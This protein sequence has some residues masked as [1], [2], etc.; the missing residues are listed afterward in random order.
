MKN[1]KEIIEPMDVIPV[2]NK[3]L[4]HIGDYLSEKTL[5]FKIAAYQVMLPPALKG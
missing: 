5:C 4:L 1:L 2:L 3:E